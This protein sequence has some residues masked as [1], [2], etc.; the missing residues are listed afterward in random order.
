MYAQIKKKKKKQQ[1]KQTD[2]FLCQPSM[3][4]E[5]WKKKA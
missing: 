1:A 2:A 5:Q 4:E 3:K